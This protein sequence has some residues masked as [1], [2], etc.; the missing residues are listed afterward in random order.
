MNPPPSDVWNNSRYDPSLQNTYTEI[1]MWSSSSWFKLVHV[2]LFFNLFS[3]YSTLTRWSLR[4]M[5]KSTFVGH[6]SYSLWLIASSRQR[7]I[8]SRKIKLP[9]LL[10]LPGSSIESA[11]NLFELGKPSTWKYSSDNRTTKWKWG[12]CLPPPLHFLCS[13]NL[14]ND[15]LETGC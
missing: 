6:R 7:W 15:C 11:T 14:M 4:T 3:R 10:L 12:R 1:W 13:S 9:S 8:C 5:R 2:M